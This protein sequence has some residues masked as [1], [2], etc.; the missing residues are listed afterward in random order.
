MT[1]QPF[2]TNIIH[3]TQTWFSQD[4]SLLDN[5]FLF[6]DVVAISQEM[7]EDLTSLLLDFEKAYDRI[8]L[9]FLRGT[10]EKLGLQLKYLQLNY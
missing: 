5:I 9:S 6:W 3:N 10:M 8:Y 2:L 1:L 7:K 4:R